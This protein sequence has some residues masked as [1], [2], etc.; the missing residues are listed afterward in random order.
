MQAGRSGWKQVSGVIWDRRIAGS[1]KVKVYKMVARA[2]MMYGL[3]TAALTQRR[4]AELEGTKL[5]TL[6]FSLR[7]TRMDKIRNERDSSG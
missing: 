4:E 3:E 1:V 5:K 7:V 2:A 6:R